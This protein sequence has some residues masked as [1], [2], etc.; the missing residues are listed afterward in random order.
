MEANATTFLDYE[1]HAL[2][3][4]LA[5]LKSFAL[6]EATVPAA[7]LAPLAAV[8]IEQHLSQARRDIRDCAHRFLDWLHGPAGHDASAHE[9]QRRFTLLRLR[10]GHVLTQFD[11]YLDVLTQRSENETGVWLAGLDAVAADALALPGYY[12]TPP[13][14]CYLDRGVGAAIRRARTRLPGGGENPV[15]IIRVPRE[16]MVGTGIASSL[17]HEVGHQ[18]AALLD[19][20]TTLREQLQRRA[21]L[22]TGEQLNPWQYWERWISE[23]VADLW[24][25]ARVGICSTMGLIGVVSLPRAFVF[26]IRLDDP[27][28]F[29]WLRVNLSCA[30]GAEL[31][32][33]PQWGQLAALWNA[34]YPSSGPGGELPGNARQVLH[35]LTESMPEFIAMLASHRSPA[36]KGDSLGDVLQTHDVEPARLTGHFDRWGAQPASMYRARPSLVFAV[37]GQARADGRLDAQEESKLIAKLLT[38]W[39]LR[40]SLDAAE[41]CVRQPAALVPAP[42]I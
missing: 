30:M 24:S 28:P 3:S 26:R 27:H 33:H 37:L 12:A 14:V 35:A 6:Q 41:R 17:I 8:A 7:G 21:D 42:V 11:L 9:A 19:L 5:R 4:R 22:H 23:I 34:F 20:V 1:A 40:N 32:P 10:F 13:V 25:V 38:H 39:A 36:L 15:A 31:F 16:R 2:L 18:A 29:A